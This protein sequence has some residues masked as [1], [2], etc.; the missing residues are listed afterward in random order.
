[1]DPRANSWDRHQVG[2]PSLRTRRCIKPRTFQGLTGPAGRA[3]RRVKEQTRYNGKYTLTL[4]E[5][6]YITLS[7]GLIIYIDKADGTYNH[8]WESVAIRLIRKVT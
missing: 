5:R 4:C 8:S 3:W 6:N 1:M 7:N 2:T